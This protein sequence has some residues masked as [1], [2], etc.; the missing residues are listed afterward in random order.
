M[1]MATRKMFQMCR[2]NNS[3]TKCLAF[4]EKKISESETAHKKLVEVFDCV[5][6]A[7]RKTEAEMA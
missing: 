2:E 1:V 6:A 5:K 3:M 4:M 7:H